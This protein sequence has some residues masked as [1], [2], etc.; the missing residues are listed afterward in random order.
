MRERLSSAAFSAGWGLVCRLPES[1]ARALFNFG[2]DIPRMET[3]GRSTQ[4]MAQVVRAEGIDVMLS[5]HSR[6]DGSQ[7]KLARLREAGGTGPNPFVVGEPTV[8][9]TLTVMNECSLAQ[10]DRFALLR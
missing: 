10:R 1:V 9:R 8:E 7:G 6:V 5:N 4:R 3:Y 2:A